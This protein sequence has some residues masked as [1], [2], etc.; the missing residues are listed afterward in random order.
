MFWKKKQTTS[1]V[2][3][4]PGADT[5]VKL[6]DVKIKA[7]KLK[8]EKFSG[9]RPIPGLVGKHLINEFKLNADLVQ[10]LKAVQHKRPQN[11]AVFDIRVFDQSEADAEEVQIKDYLS[12]NEHPNLVLYEGW[13]DEDTKHVEMAEKKKINFDVPLFTEAEILGKIEELS[14][15]GSSVFFYQAAGMARG[16]P[17]GM[18]AAIVELNPNH[19]N[20]GKKYN[21]YTANVVGLEPVAN[22][23]KLFDS[24]KPKEIARW[25]IQAHQK[26]KY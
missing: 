18:G 10:L 9:P 6:S 19:P 5:A 21:I 2:I 15:P 26:R 24:N 16:G 23:Q 12:F 13:F 4:E 1:T 22:K 11:E 8:T 20:K 14:E 25:T 17:L 7:K 3:E